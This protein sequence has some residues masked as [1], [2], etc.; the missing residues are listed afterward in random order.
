M[1]FLAG[2]CRVFGPGDGEGVERGTWSCRTLICRRRGARDIA[3]TVSE[4][5]PGRS[6]AVLNPGAEEV[7]YV[8]RGQGACHLGGFPYGLEPGVGV[9]VPPNT[10]YH[11]ENPGPEKLV[12]VAVCCP[13]DEQ[14][15][16]ADEPPA[17]VATGA[18]PR[19]TVREQERPPIPVSDRHFKLLVNEELGC[20][21]VTQFVGFIPPSKAPFHYH[22]YEEAIYILEGEGIVHVEGGSCAFAPGTS[23]YLP[24]GLRHCLENPGPAPV[25]LLGAFYP[26]GSPAVAYETR[27]RQG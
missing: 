17:A 12:V 3:E 15:R 6:P 8:V 11:M 18:A 24:V 25:R 19:R 27:A 16:V 14:R 23:I 2:G 20:Q 7:L 1:E 21:R 4:Y 10:P 26:S 9:Y 5:G 13:E 22:T